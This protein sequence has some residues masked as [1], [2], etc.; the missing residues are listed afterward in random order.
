MKKKSIP[1]LAKKLKELRKKLN[2]TQKEVAAKA[3]ITESAYRAYELG[4]RNPKPGILDRIAKVLG[5]RPE[6]LSAPAFKNRR[7]FAYALLENEDIFGYT[8]R[9]IDGTTAIVTGYSPDMSSFTEFIQEWGSMRK[10]LDD[11]EITKDEYEGWKRTW[12]N[13]T[14]DK[15]IDS[16]SPYTGG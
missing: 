8:V 13:S 4:D 5:V 10:K 3:H 12:D 14:W 6:Y 1:A 11:R 15:T 7:E 16:I 9:D 2:L